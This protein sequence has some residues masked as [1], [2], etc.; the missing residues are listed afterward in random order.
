MTKVPIKIFVSYALQDEVHK[1]ALYR[2]LSVLKRQG[3]IEA[4]DAGTINAGD[5]WNSR[6]Q[7][8]LQEANIILLLLSSDTLADDYIHDTQIQKALQRAAN[9]EA[10]LIPILL[11]SV[12]Y[13][14]LGV[15]QYAALPSNGKAVTLWANQDEA[16]T[17]IASEI[18]K[19]VENM[20]GFQNPQKQI[21]EKGLLSKENQA[22]QPTKIIHQTAEKIYN[23]DKIDN[24]NFS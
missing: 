24:A 7:Q 2:H 17:H 3:V 16:W 10:I 11:R 22:A 13:K 4:F 5:N 21:S 14:G 9:K 1:N 23:I 15:E 8:Y 20:D 12:D 19:V 18:R 6:M